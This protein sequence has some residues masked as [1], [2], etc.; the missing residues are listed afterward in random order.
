[1]TWVNI[2]ER[3]PRPIVKEWQEDWDRG[4][5]LPLPLEDNPFQD[6][7]IVERKKEEP[8]RVIEIQL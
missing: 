7:P 3:K 6:R 2:K 5:Q 1:M 4:I 8:K